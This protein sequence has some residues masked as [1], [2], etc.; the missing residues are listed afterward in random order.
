MVAVRGKFCLASSCRMS[1]FGMNPV[2]GGS[3]PSDSNTIVAVAV[4]IGALGQHSASVLIF[5]AIKDLN[6]KKAADVIIIY[7]DRAI[8]ASCGIG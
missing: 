6:V 8:I 3:P 1:H 4:V 5:V 7:V 2:S